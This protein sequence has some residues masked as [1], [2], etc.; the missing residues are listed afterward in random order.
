MQAPDG[1]S[2][3]FVGAHMDVV[4]ANPENWDRD[5]FKLNI[6]GD[7]LY[8]RGARSMDRVTEHRR[9]NTALAS[10]HMSQLCGCCD[11]TL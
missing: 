7:K 10:R 11:L 6:E 5:P 9:T 1:G 8:G 4:P 2:V 3:A